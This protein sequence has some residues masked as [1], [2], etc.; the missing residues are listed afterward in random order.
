LLYFKLELGS[1][2]RKGVNPDIFQPINFNALT[3]DPSILNRLA[4]IFESNGLKNNFDCKTI[5]GQRLAYE[6]CEI[7]QSVIDRKGD[8]L[9]SGEVKVYDQKDNEVE[10]G[11]EYLKLKKLLDEPNPM[12]GRDE[13]DKIVNIFINR[14]GFCPIYKNSNLNPSGLPYAIWALDPQFFT[15]QLSNKLFKQTDIKQIVEWIEFSGYNTEKMRLT[16]DELGDVWILNYGIPQQKDMYVHQSPLYSVGDLASLFNKSVDVFGQ[17]VEKSV[18]G[19]VT[20]K[21]AD[22][23]GQ[24]P[25]MPNDKKNLQLEFNRYGLTK[26]KD[27]VIITDKNLFYQSM[28]SNVGNLQIPEGIKISVEGICRKLNFAPELLSKDAT[29]DNKKVAEIKQYQNVTIPFANSYYDAL[30]QFLYPNGNGLIIKRDYDDLPV[31]QSD[32]KLEAEVY[33]TNAD[34]FNTLVGTGKFN[35]EQLTMIAKEL[36]LIEEYEIETQKN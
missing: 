21:T 27:Q 25:L 4:A 18:L 23:T 12:Q 17:L 20:N 30:T 3:D 11:S 22:V 28:L 35:D 1:H 8:Y 6:E 32:K 29:F 31:L 5:N 16:G 9:V 15:Y 14:H 2:K 26:T 34:A 13:F 36:D 7:I 24:T 33:N 19:M 10:T